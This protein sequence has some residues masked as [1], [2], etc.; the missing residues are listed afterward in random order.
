MGYPWY[1]HHSTSMIMLFVFMN[2]AIDNGYTLHV[3][4][5]FDGLV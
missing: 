2:T 5:I 1:F 4:N 3:T